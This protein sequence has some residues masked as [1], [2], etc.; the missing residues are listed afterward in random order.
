[1]LSYTTANRIQEIRGFQCIIA[2]KIIVAVIISVTF[3][4]RSPTKTA[5]GS[6]EVHNMRFVTDF[7]LT[8]AHETKADGQLRH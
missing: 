4:P 6:F 2:L 1:M 8:L 5:L 3:I 7:F